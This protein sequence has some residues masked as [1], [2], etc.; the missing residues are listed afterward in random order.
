[1][2]ELNNSTICRDI[3]YANTMV[4]GGG[5]V[6]GRLGKKIRGKEKFM[7]IP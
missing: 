7:N 3:Y 1:M 2:L 5:G 6:D 4:G